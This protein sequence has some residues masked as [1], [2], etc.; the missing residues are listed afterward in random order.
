LAV[1]VLFLPPSYCRLTRLLCRALQRRC[2]RTIRL[3]MGFIPPKS[4]LARALIKAD[5][6]V[7]KNNLPI[8]L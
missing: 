3:F 8:I 1:I 2:S 4:A 6:V 7:S 5:K